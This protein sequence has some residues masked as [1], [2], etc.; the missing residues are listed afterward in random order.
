[1]KKSISL[2]SLAILILLVI[3]AYV[4]Y[5]YYPQLFG[6]PNAAVLE[7]KILLT[8][9]KKDSEKI[10]PGSLV[11]VGAKI[12]NV[13]TKASAPGKVT[14]RYAFLKPLDEH[15][16]SVLYQTEI[17]PLPSLQPDQEIEVAFSMPHQWPSLADFIK[18]DWALRQYQ[19][20]VTVQTQKEFLIGSKAIS[21]SAYY[22][23]G[24]SHE[25]ATPVPSAEPDIP[26]SN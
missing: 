26:H 18:N 23:G 21:Y 2:W 20:I 13:G 17:L 7:G 3:L 5:N 24:P 15:T 12:T 11:N 16:K 1:M 19:V 10:A 9:V 22:Y 14:I 4:G 6:H 25:I 8:P